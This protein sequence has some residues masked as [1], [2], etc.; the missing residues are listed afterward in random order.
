MDVEALGN[1]LAALPLPAVL[2][3]PSERVL[4]MN[5]PATTL[6]GTGLEGRHYI[7]ALRQPGLLDAVEATRA[8]GI[9]RQVEY[10]AHDG[11]QDTTWNVTV[12][13]VGVGLLL[14]FEDRT[15]A[16]EVGQMRRDFVANVS[17]ELRTPLT[18]LIGYI[19][20]LQGPAKDDAV[21]RA[22]FLDTMAREAQ[23]MNRLVSDLLSLSRVEA[24]ARVRP[25]ATVELVGLLQQVVGL[26][27]TIADEAGAT[28]TLDCDVEA[29]AVAGDGD[30][31]RQVFVNL[32]ENAIKY[33][34]G[35]V[36]I[37]LSSDPQMRVLRGP[38]VRVDVTDNGR[39]IDPVHLPRLTER[40]YR[41]DT[42]RSREV[43]GTGLG[44][45]IV[46]HILNRHRGRLRISSQPG[47]G[48]RFSVLLPLKNA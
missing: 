43:G 12:A 1:L 28:I 45:A 22:R 2:I 33:G 34:G 14:S 30:Q 6:L 40:F 29:A 10:L 24:D 5:L 17:H 7:T 47:Q 3:G 9:A 44:L 19:E 48:S 46:K 42:H 26:L 13:P 39:G 27:R 15:A 23:R 37:T 38:G 18:A 20:T 8:S 25:T 36:R 31:L 41:I 35:T 21:A 16:Q 11:A 4:R 32:T